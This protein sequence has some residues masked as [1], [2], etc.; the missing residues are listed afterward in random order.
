VSNP[1]ATQRRWRAGFTEWIAPSFSPT[2]PRAAGRLDFSPTPP[3]AAGRLDFSPTPPRAAGRLDFSPTPPR[4]AGR[5]DFSGA[6]ASS[7]CVRP[8]SLRP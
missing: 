4:A 5:L 3:R 6:A 1:R 7:L 8:P 2:P